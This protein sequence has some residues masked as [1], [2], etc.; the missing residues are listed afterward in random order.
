[1]I[2]VVLLFQVGAVA[3]AAVQELPMRGV[4][5]QITLLILAVLA[6]LYRIILAVV[7]VVQVLPVL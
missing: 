4:A 5:F 2:P 3:G 7:V 6:L 1:M